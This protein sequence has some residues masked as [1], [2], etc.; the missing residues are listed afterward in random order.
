MSVP[1]LAASRWS[2]RAAFL[3]ALVVLGC[4]ASPS[5]RIDVA[6]Q[7]AARASLEGAWRGSYW[8]GDSGRSGGIRFRLEPG[9]E[10]A[11]G[12]V[13]MLDRAPPDATERRHDRF[14]GA[15]AMLT[16]HL[17]R[18]DD[19][20][21]VAGALEPYRD[22]GCGCTLSTSFVG[23]IDGDRIE[24]S[25]LSHGGPGHIPTSGRWQAARVASTP[26]GD[27]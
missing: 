16:V 18:V 15:T 6:G 19:L 20:G 23:R 2:I 27:W 21:T 22:P 7:P 10:T 26:P 1:G 3:T 12:E 8:S 13:T 4:S 25:F 9:M 5:P 14:D 24:G 17:V 11:E